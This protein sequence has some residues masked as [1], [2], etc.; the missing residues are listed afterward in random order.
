[1]GITTG[2]LDSRYQGPDMDPISS[3]ADYDPFMSAIDSAF[4][5]AINTYV[6]TDLKYGEQMTY[7]PSSRSRDGTG[8]TCI[9]DRMATGRADP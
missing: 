2:R 9:R 5:A 4:A 3:Q 7:K 8:M 1:M 6:R